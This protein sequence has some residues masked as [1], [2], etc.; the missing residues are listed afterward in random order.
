MTLNWESLCKF[1][2][3]AARIREIALKPKLSNIKMEGDTDSNMDEEQPP[4]ER[5]ER[6]TKSLHLFN[7]DKTYKL[8]AVEDMSN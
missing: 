6:D 8:D 2:L 7:C 5:K 1:H 4:R 3:K